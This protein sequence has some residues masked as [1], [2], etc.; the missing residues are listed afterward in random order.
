M[1]DIKKNILDK[2]KKR[3]TLTLAGNKEY[4]EVLEFN[5]GN[6]ISYGGDTISN[7]EEYRNLITDD[8]ALEKICNYYRDKAKTF[9]NKSLSELTDVY[10][11]M[12]EN[13]FI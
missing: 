10:N 1:I 6:F 13:S 8:Q 12:I 4:Y 11:Y 2:I 9:G 3:G 7:I 5:N